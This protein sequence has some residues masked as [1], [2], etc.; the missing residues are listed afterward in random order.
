MPRTSALVQNIMSAIQSFV[1]CT[2]KCKHGEGRGDPGLGRGAA[3]KVELVADGSQAP[4]AK[5][6][7]K[8]REIERERE[9]ASKI[10]RARESER[11]NETARESE[12][13]IER[14]R[15]SKREREAATRR[16]RERK[17]ESVRE[18]EKER[19]HLG[20]GTGNEVELV[21]NGGQNTA[22]TRILAL[23]QNMKSAVHS[24]L[25]YSQSSRYAGV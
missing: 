4:L 9:K 7:T 5:I 11:E 3:N 10:E 24:F 14:E 18:R 15:E 1:E 12:R 22:R 16:Y 6:E 17:R 2:R 8:R 13:E 19:A 25:D 20:R 21:A 23:A